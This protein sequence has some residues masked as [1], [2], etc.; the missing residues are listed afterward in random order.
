MGR[1]ES[2]VRS[3]RQARTVPAVFGDSRGQSHLVES[4]VVTDHDVGFSLQNT[5]ELIDQNA[6]AVNEI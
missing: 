4:D 5:M 1:T 2:N 6:F 3:G